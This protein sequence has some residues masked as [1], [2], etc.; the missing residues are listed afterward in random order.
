VY[1]IIFLSKH[2]NNQR[3]LLSPYYHDTIHYFGKT[4]GVPFSHPREILTGRIEEKTTQV[5]RREISDFLPNVTP[6]CKITHKI[7][8]SVKQSEKARFRRSS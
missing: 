4:K 2:L 3:T 6:V 7:P 5:K 1:F 8:A